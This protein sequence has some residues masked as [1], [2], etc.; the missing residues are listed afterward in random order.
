MTRG[1]SR[2]R[3]TGSEKEKNYRETGEQNLADLKDRREPQRN[4]LTQRG[5]MSE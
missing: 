3:K 4:F 5:N 1:W 2:M